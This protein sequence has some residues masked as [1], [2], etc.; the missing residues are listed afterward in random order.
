MKKSKRF[1]LIELLVVIA[2]IAILAGM[3]L[4]AL[5]N[6]REKARSSNCTNNLKQ[7]ML[8]ELQYADDFNGWHLPPGLNS[9]SWA[10]MLYTHKYLSD[11]NM[12]YCPALPPKGFN[13]A[14]RIKTQIN[15]VYGKHAMPEKYNNY[16]TGNLYYRISAENVKNASRIWLF[17][18]SAFK[19]NPVKQWQTIGNGSGAGGKIHTRHAGERANIAFMDGGVRSHTMVSL[20]GATIRS[21][22]DYKDGAGNNV[23]APR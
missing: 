12:V 4:P 9:L 11:A 10:N 16:D 3:L 18:D 23:A 6:A 22:Y 13:P 15:D 7:I 14:D 8:H 21:V 1:T 17:A 19:T 5:N 20:L 2:I